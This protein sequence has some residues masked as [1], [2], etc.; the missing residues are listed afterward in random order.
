[1]VYY[2]PHWIWPSKIWTFIRTT[3]CQV[4]TKTGLWDA[5]KDSRLKYF[6]LIVICTWW[7]TSK[8]SPQL[9]L[10]GNYKG[11]VCCT[12]NNSSVLSWALYQSKYEYINSL[13]GYTTSSCF[14]YLVNLADLWC[15]A[16]YEVYQLVEFVRLVGHEDSETKTNSGISCVSPTIASHSAP[17]FLLSMFLLA[18][19]QSK[20]APILQLLFC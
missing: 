13:N 11:S 3:C 7:V 12:G 18:L 16:T 5:S 10:G 19:P 14:Q 9:P 1:M 17:L 15:L 8:T 2:T 4:E 6:Y 20:L